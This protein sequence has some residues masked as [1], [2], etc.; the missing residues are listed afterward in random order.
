Y[1][2]MELIAYLNISRHKHCDISYWRTKTGLE[3]D[4]ILGNAQVAIE[5][6]ISE[7]VHKQDLNGLIAFCEEHP[8]TKPIVVS[9]DKRARQLV[10]NDQ[11]N[12]MIMPWQS[13]LKKLW[14]GEII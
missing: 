13:F 10:I 8:N 3:V 11:L 1:I 14:K 6:K 9:Q 5:V 2:F 4:F 12:I 7:Q